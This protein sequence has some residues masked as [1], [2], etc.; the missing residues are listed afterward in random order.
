MP[1]AEPLPPPPWVRGANKS[2][3]R[4]LSLEAILESAMRILES[5]GLDAVTMRRVAQDMGTA[6]GS[7]YA[8]VRNKAELHELLLD[9]ALAP[10]H[11]PEPDPAR[12]RDQLLELL[13]GTARAMVAKPGIARVSMETAIPTTPNA[14]R[15]MDGVLALLDAGG[16]PPREALAAAD[17]LALHLTAAA[18]EMSV[19][20]TPDA[21]AEELQR[22]T[23]QITQ[24]LE[25]LPPDRLSHL[26][27][28]QNLFETEEEADVDGLRLGLEMLLD[29]LRA[30]SR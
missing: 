7:L 10:V 12:W 17:V 26:R 18:Y 19:G 21:A 4:Q 25:L 11:V 14:L 6:A 22:R 1:T 9:A 24:Y 28:A 15:L 3:R 27:A 5:E 20:G 8:H 16:I 30:R 29:G 13:T 23:S 2:G